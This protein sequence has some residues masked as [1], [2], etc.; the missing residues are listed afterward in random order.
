M[1]SDPYRFIAERCARQRSDV[2]ET[3]LLLRRAACAVGAEAA[4]VF[5]EPERFMRRGALPITALTLPQDR[6]G[7]LGSVAV[8]PSRRSNALRLMW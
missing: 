1:L 3:R 6:A 2:L 8:Q 4:R 5:S 7:D